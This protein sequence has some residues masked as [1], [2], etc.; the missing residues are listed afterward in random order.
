MKN[1]KCSMQNERNDL[2]KTAGRI[3]VPLHFAFFILH[4]DLELMG[5]WVN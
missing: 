5:G 1:A 2:S 3:G 4:F